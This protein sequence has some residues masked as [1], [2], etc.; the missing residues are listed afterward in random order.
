MN[1]ITKTLSSFATAL[2]SHI[3]SHAGEGKFQ[4]KSINV[5]DKEWTSNHSKTADIEIVY[6][7]KSPRILQRCVYIRA[8]NRFTA[9]S[10]YS[11]DQI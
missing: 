7:L 8:E 5:P 11:E 2:E 10:Y 6:L 1:R 9:P 4:I 3:Q